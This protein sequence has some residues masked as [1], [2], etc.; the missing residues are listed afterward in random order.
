VRAA[1]G[2]RYRPEPLTYEEALLIINDNKVFMMIAVV[3]S[4]DMKDGP[5]QIERLTDAEKGIETMTLTGPLTLATLFELQEAIRLNPQPKTIINL[6]GVPYID[7]AGLGAILSFHAACQRTGRRY[8]LVAM[9]PR[10]KTMFAASKVDALLNI[11]PT[12]KEAEQSL[13]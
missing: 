1:V 4:I 5:L 11:L 3:E 6:A 2:N 7:S 8:A 10:V 9:P 12:A 13:S